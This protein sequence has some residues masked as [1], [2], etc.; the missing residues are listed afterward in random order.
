MCAQ[1]G[2]GA[3]DFHSVES[4]GTGRHLISKLMLLAEVA[5]MAAIVSHAQGRAKPERTFDSQVP[6]A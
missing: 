2:K 3:A 6:L 1:M 4:R 5:A